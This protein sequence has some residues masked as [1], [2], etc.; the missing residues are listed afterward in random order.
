MAEGDTRLW[1]SS[2]VKAMS[3]RAGGEEAPPNIEMHFGEPPDVS[4]VDRGPPATDFTGSTSSIPAEAG[5][6]PRRF[7]T[8]SSMS[9]T[10]RATRGRSR[11]IC[12]LTG[13]GARESR[14]PEK[15]HSLLLYPTLFFASGGS[16]QAGRR[17]VAKWPKDVSGYGLQPTAPIILA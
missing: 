8:N 16:D 15:N 2:E 13:N 6:S 17:Y 9:S 12:A 4:P 14:R 10:N 3:S 5:D 1:A 11:S 7:A